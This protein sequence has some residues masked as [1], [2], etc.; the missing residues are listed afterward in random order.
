VA[1]VRRS[2]RNQRQLLWGTVEEAFFVQRQLRRHDTLNGEGSRDA[3]DP[4]YH[5][6]FAGDLC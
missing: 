6:G 5:F 2:F 1:P 4:G 3:H